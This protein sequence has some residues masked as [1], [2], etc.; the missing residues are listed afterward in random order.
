MRRHRAVFAVTVATRAEQHDRRQGQPAANRVHHNGAGEIMELGTGQRLDPR[1][2]AE[3]LVPDDAFKKWIDESD[4]DG[5]G[6]QLRVKPRT[7]GNAAR[8][9]GRNRCC[10]G[11]QEKELH[12]LVTILGGELFCADEEM[13]AVGN[14]VAY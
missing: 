3:I 10:K 7:F 11:Q 2:H 12:Q 1:L 9:D 4:D 13:R 5:G 14:P 8:N 6:D